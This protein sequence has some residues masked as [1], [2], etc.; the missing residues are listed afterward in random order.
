MASVARPSTPYETMRSTLITT[1][2]SHI[3]DVNE[4]Q[5]K[6]QETKRRTRKSIST[7]IEFDKVPVDWKPNHAYISEWD[8]KWAD[9][10]DTCEYSFVK[11]T[12]DLNYLLIVLPSEYKALKS[13]DKYS[14]EIRASEEILYVHKDKA[15]YFMKNRHF[16]LAGDPKD[17]YTVTIPELGNT[18]HKYLPFKSAVSLFK[19]EGLSDAA[20]CRLI[21][22]DM[23]KIPNDCNDITEFILTDTVNIGDCIMKPKDF[24]YKDFAGMSQF[25]EENFGSREEEDPS[26]NGY[27]GNTDNHNV[28]LAKIAEEVIP[29]KVDENINVEKGDAIALIY[30]GSYNWKP[31]S[32]GEKQVPYHVVPIIDADDT[33]FVTLEADAGDPDRKLP[34]F[35]IYSKQ[36]DSGNTFYDRYSGDYTLRDKNKIN[37]TL[38]DVP[39]IVI[40]L[41]IAPKVKGIDSDIIRGGKSPR[42]KRMKRRKSIVIKKKSGK[43]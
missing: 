10:S 19:K 2:N 43:Q 14:S 36:S 17:Y 31:S 21:D 30:M 8:Y 5:L 35:D 6:L 1:F 20:I 13:E 9:D 27:F 39:P 18:S 41:S 25:E 22:V 26:C 33:S 32:S 37:K 28:R 3:T 38:P 24:D 40:T 42:R 16:V 23:M 12:D 29:D 7:P 15:K 11:C 34:V 4:A